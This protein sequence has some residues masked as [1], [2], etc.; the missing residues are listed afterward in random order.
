[1]IVRRT[2]TTL[3][4]AL[5]LTSCVRQGP[6]APVITPG[7]GEPPATAVAPSRNAPPA[8]TPQQR[9]PHPDKVTV[10][11]GET[12]YMISRRYDLPLRS[13]IDANRLAPPYQLAAGTVLALPR[14]RFH[15]VQPGDTLYSISRTYGVELSTLA[16]INHLAPPYALRS[17]QVLDLPA[18]VAPPERVAASPPAAQ[19]PPPAAPAPPA[20]QAAPPAPSGPP[21]A[22]QATP[23][24][25]PEP[26][27]PKP[28][29]QAAVLPGSPRGAGN[30]SWPLEGRVVA[31][32][33]TGPGGTHNDGINIAARVGETVHA[34]EGGVV[35]YA[36]N[37]LRG[38][39]NLV[40]IKH[41]GGYMTAYAHN[42]KLLV[43]RGDTVK[44]GQAIATAGA[45][46]M[47]GSPQLH[48]EIRRGTRALDPIAYLPPLRPSAG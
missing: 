47:V 16:S 5:A 46:G 27:P 48:F 19:G 25:G 23:Q 41:P 36:G 22:A 11:K 9:A 2:A 17:G 3:L 1:M 24:V 15:L 18:S 44:R 32:Y 4:G 21:P 42:A 26:P 8:T 37:E 14:E 10:A 34:A 29:P 40:L 30:F 35:A 7:E 13:I 31:S 45:T 43:R 28:A 12:L 6:P 39:G 33:G 38:Y 20:A